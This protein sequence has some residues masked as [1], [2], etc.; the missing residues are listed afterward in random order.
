ME[1]G[2]LGGLGLHMGGG[3]IILFT[4]TLFPI[5]SKDRH[6]DSNTRQ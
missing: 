5:K 4:F 2:L 3:F 6:N 1:L